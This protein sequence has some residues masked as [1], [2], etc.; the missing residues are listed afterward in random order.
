MFTGV[1]KR[2]YL[3]WLATDTW[4]SG[5]DLDMKRFY[6]FVHCYVVY[7]RKPLDGNSVYR[8]LMERKFSGSSDPI[9]NNIARNFASLFDQLVDYERCIRKSNWGPLPRLAKSAHAS[10]SRR[11]TDNGSR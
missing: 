6:R 9:A 2:A 8:D 7:A 4:H 1:T 3:N 10:D 5:H 11:V